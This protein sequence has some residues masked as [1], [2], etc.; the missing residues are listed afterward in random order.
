M[1]RS[2]HTDD[3]LSARLDI[4][5]T[6]RFE[7]DDWEVSSITHTL[8]TSTN[9]QIMVEA[10]MEVRMNAKVVHERNWQLA[11]PRQLL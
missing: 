4:T 3:P 10:D 6:E 1:Y 2:I 8:V 7:R 11:F 9:T 5:W